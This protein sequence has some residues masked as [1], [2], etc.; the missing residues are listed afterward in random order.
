MSKTQLIR[1]DA[2]AATDPAFRL[3]AAGTVFFV[4]QE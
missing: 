2:T 1:P 3:V 4:V